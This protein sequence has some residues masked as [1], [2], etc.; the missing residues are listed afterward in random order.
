MNGSL[1]GKVLN[2]TEESNEQ[3][4]GKHLNIETKTNGLKQKDCLKTEKKDKQELNDT[5]NIKNKDDVKDDKNI[6]KESVE[7]DENVKKG[8]VEN[9]ENMKKESIE[10]DEE[11]NSQV[12]KK[13]KIEFDNADS[14]IER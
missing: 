2:G 7:D 9:D 8:S 4:S 5:K 11:S 12:S 13:I 10:D 3:D 6:K 14:A 1:K